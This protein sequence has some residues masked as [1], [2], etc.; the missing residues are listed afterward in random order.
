MAQCLLPFRALQARQQQV[1]Q[2]V[3]QGKALPLAR[4]VAA[5]HDDR[6]VGAVSALDHGSKSRNLF[7]ERRRQNLQALFLEKLCQAG[8]RVTA[9]IPGLP[10]QHYAVKH[11]VAVY[12]HAMD[13]VDRQDEMARLDALVARRRPGLVTVWGR[14]RV[15]KTRLL[16][17]WSRRHGGLYTVADLSAP[18]VQRRYMAEA[19]AAKFDGFADV[20]YPDWRSLLRRIAAEAS[21]ASWRGPLVIDEFPYLVESSPELLSV[22]QAWV[23]HEAK[24]SGL[25]VALAGSTQRMMQGLAIDATSPLYGRAV[26]AI[27]LQPMP[28]AALRDALR[29]GAASRVIE[30]YATWGGLPRY[31]ELAEPFA[32][33][34]DEA[35]DAL[36]LDPLGPLHS[37]PDRLLL[38]ERPPALP[39]RPVLDAVGAGAHRLSEV[40]A[41][42][43]TPATALSRPL[44][45]LM[46]MGLVRRERPFGDLDRGGGKR[47][48]YDIA[49]PF[50]RLWFR[51]VAPR[52]SLFA[53]TNREGRLQEWRRHR[54]ALVAATWEDLCRRS[55]PSLSRPGGPLSSCGQ[56]GPAAR[57]WRGAGPEW[58]VVSRSVDGSTLLIGEAKW[59]SRAMDAP[60]LEG[61]LEALR[62]KGVPPVSSGKPP[63][64]VHALF[65]PVRGKL[66]SGRKAPFLVVDADDVV[67]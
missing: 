18:P 35:L 60:A 29:P 41:R 45:R 31:W 26:E 6:E 19:V 37:E 67:S 39:L 64:V 63:R 59:S 24:A 8:D 7:G 23:D 15:G 42:L 46:E 11:N 2:L 17:E 14:R 9:K 5:G 10:D 1:R 48:L 43:G 38:E 53:S 61:A 21:R 12:N 27:A 57:F 13:F 4:L 62:A 28:P 55:V 51:V 34:V 36:V 22:M 44:S 30:A 50:L 25:L 65:I 47:S 56:L 32:D 66:R 20:E 3:R 40:A 54:A 52:R 33:V 16:L 58:D 49:D